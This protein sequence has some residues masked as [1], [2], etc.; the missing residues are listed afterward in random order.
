[1]VYPNEC[2]QHGKHPEPLI[3]AIHKSCFSTLE[4]FRL[5][6]MARIR[7]VALTKS[8][9][10]LKIKWKQHHYLYRKWVELLS[11]TEIHMT[12]SDAEKLHA[13]V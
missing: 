2:K 9:L 13:Q 5:V 12:M 1:M 4:I 10:L 3:E 7:R 11:G 6:F 8:S